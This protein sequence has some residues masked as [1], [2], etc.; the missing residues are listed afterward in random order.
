MTMKLFIAHKVSGE[1]YAKLKRDVIKVCTAL[2]EVGHKCYCSFLDGK[3]RKEAN[4]KIKIENAL[5]KINESDGILAIVKSD[6][7]SEGMLIEVGYAKAKG[8]KIVLLI[9]KDINDNYIGAIATKIIEF[10]E[11][12]D[13]YDKMGAEVR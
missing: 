9:N 5:S 13:V 6:E 10:D 2:R 11:L 12:N 8:K 3:M 7:K 4:K 1:D